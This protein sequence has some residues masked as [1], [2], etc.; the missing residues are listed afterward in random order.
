[1]GAAV[2]EGV[3]EE[4][5]SAFGHLDRDGVLFDLSGD[6]SLEFQELLL[7]ILAVL[8]YAPLMAAGNHPET[9]VLLGG[10]VD[11]QPGANADI[12]NRFTIRRFLDVTE[13]PGILMPANGAADAG[14]LEEIEVIGTEQIF[15]KQLGSYVQLSRLADV[16]SE[17]LAEEVD[18]KDAVDSS[19]L[20][21]TVYLLFGQLI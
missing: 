9:A 6:V 12:F 18:A 19:A 15:P 5:E 16:V 11:G 4:N 8:D 21:E 20:T 1:M 7:F 17:Q 13:I 14:R 10:L 2:K 3:V